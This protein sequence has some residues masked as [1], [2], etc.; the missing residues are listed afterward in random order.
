MTPDQKAC[1]EAFEQWS[2]E[3]SNDYDIE[4]KCGSSINPYTER[5][6]FYAYDAYSAAWRNRTE[7]L[8]KLA[9]GDF[10][11]SKGIGGNDKIWIQRD[12]GEGGTFDIKEFEAA[13]EAFFVERM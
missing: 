10:N 2:K 1:Q 8:R 11:L 4:D 5:E 13:I 3:S 9:V 6:T 7:A 12:G